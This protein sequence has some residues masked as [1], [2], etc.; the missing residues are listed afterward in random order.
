MAGVGSSLG[1]IPQAMKAGNCSFVMVS[2]PSAKARS[3]LPH[4]AQV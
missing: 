4:A 3:S 1:T 2:L